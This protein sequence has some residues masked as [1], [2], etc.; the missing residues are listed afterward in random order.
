MTRL[1][2]RGTCS[3]P[4]STAAS[5]SKSCS[6]RCSE[7]GPT[8]CAPTS[9]PS[10]STSAV[11]FQTHVVTQSVLERFGLAKRQLGARSIPFFVNFLIGDSSNSTCP[12]RGSGGHPALDKLHAALGEESVWCISPNDHVAVWP[13]FFSGAVRSLAKTGTILQSYPKSSAITGL[14][15]SWLFCDVHGIVGALRNGLYATPRPPDYLWVFDYDISWVGDLSAFIWAFASEPAD[16]LVAK[17]HGQALKH[18]NEHGQQ[19]YSQFNVRNY[20]ADG[21]VR[22]SLL[23]PVRYS[24]R[25]LAATRTLIHRN[26]SAFCETRGAS[27]CG[28]N[29]WCRES[30][31]MQLRPDLFN[32]NFSCC[33]SHSDRYSRERWNL[34]NNLPAGTRPPVQLL[35]RV[36][37]EGP[38]VGVASSLRSAGG[39]QRGKP[40]APH[41]QPKTSAP[42]APF[43][44]PVQHAAR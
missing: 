7:C 37:L 10:Q 38:P 32:A 36:K 28:L 3:G 8:C 19:T 14:H 39:A 26:R 4:P 42:G 35:H 31:M 25:M 2:T 24:K 30:A 27:L 18:M 41:H 40:S 12:M 16:L 33:K 17:S 6:A 29:S 21:D 44:T 1:V 5:T 9:D 20:L 23:A 15:W 43:A 11:V 34:W 13:H 22:S